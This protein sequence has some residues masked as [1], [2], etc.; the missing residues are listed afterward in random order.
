MDFIVT[1]SIFMMASF[2]SNYGMR[3][4]TPVLPTLR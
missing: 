4:V 2:D 1:L 3:S